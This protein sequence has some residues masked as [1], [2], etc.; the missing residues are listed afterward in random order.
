VGGSDLGLLEGRESEELVGEL[1]DGGES[2][3]VGTL[4]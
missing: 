4:E 3:K 2:M 1:D